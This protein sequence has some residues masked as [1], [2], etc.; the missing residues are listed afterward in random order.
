MPNC[1][2]TVGIM[3]MNNKDR[4][5]LR[6]L[7][8]RQM[9]ISLSEKNRRIVEAWKKLNRCENDIPLVHIELPNIANE[10]IPPF[11]RCQSDQARRLEQDF[12]LNFLNQ[13][14]FEDDKPVPDFFPIIPGV[15][16]HPFGFDV[17]KTK[18]NAKSGIGYHI[19]TVINDLHDEFHKLG[20][21][22]FG[23]NKEQ[24]K[25][26][27]ELAQDTFG[28]ILPV[29]LSGDCLKM[30]PTQMVVRIMGME[31]MYLAILDYPDDFKRMMRLLTDDYL[32]FFRMLEQE[33]HL[34][35]TAGFE[36][37]YQSSFAFTDELPTDVAVSTTETWGYLNSQ[38]S[39]GISPEMYAEFIFPYY[40][41][42]AQQFGLLSYGCC[43]APD[44]VW[45]QIRT[46]K[47]LR[48]LSIPVWSN[49]EYMGE[50]LRDSK[51]IY[52][53]KPSAETIGLYKT[54]DEEFVRKHINKTLHAAQGC[55]LEITQREV[56]TVHGDAGKVKR[57]VKL[58]RECIEKEW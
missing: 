13:E 4:K 56:F 47:N 40:S 20:S 34:L 33:N 37:V 22:V 32:S 5:I 21:S 28:D 45:E 36:N 43:E 55:A 7:A 39:V 44:P 26:Y 18:T 1:L 35:P 54:F 9:E 42:I 2:K 49:E 29:K 53:R 8:S 14:L 11:L 3:R 58:I 57:Y 31:N 38:E 50:Q 19:D 16:F 27:Q 17:S 10:I 51:I 6:S 41:E 12:Y 30:V 24:A 48:R 52:Q 46:L 25:T 23:V 15:Y